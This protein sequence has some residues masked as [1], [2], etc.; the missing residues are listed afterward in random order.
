MFRREVHCNICTYALEF[1][2]RRL[3]PY[4]WAEDKCLQ[5]LESGT[6]VLVGKTTSLLMVRREV[7]CNM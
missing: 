5:H 6:R 7:G 2:V 3:P 1:W 4:Q